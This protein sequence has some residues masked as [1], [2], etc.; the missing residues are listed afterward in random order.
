VPGRRTLVEQI[1]PSTVPRAGAAGANG[2][3]EHGD[4]HAAAQ[5][6]V[7]TPATALPF[8]HTL[9]QL[10]GRH[11]I[12]GVEAHTGS[13]AAA[14][15]RAMGASA[16]A[17]GHHVVLGSGTDLHTVAHEAAHV[18]QQRAGVQLRGGVGEAGDPHE[19][20][21][22]AV[23]D[24][25]VRGQSVEHLLD[26]HAGDGSGAPAV[27][28]QWVDK[29]VVDEEVQCEWLQSKEDEEVRA[30][31]WYRQRDGVWE[32]VES[33][34]LKRKR[35][36]SGSKG[37]ENNNEVVK[38]TPP[39]TTPQPTKKHKDR[40][41]DKEP[42]DPRIEPPR[43]KTI[44]KGLALVTQSDIGKSVLDRALEASKQLQFV[45]GEATRTHMDY[46]GDRGGVDT[47]ELSKNR[48]LVGGEGSVAQQLIMELCNLSNKMRFWETDYDAQNDALDEASY[49][50]RNERI[51]YDATVLVYAAWSAAQNTS[52]KQR[53]GK[54]N[55]KQPEL[56]ESWEAWWKHMQTSNQAHL[57]V[58]RKGWN[59]LRK[60]TA[61]RLP[62]PPSRQPQAPTQTPV[63]TQPPPPTQTSTQSDDP[64]TGFKL[65]DYANDPEDV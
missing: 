13:D 59:D 57:A 43:N 62:V 48:M 44:A 12:S 2:S 33:T 50:E 38:T 17:T 35:Q 64:P 30:D 10:F 3:P 46:A 11:D 23:A 18:V 61:A 37:T 6:G 34:K 27:Q 52:D 65:V 31:G 29:R 41:K 4:V 42:T 14:S 16:Y 20:H 40:Q 49:V 15:A 39:T 24:G 58:Y 54:P 60:P 7:A 8:R 22:N 21:A 36:P 53:W 55:H 19:Q 63:P 47:I 26:R 25:V 28:R 32:P 56:L 51:E 1:Q 45:V 9:Q 5:R